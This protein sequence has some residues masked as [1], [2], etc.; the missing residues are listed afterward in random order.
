MERSR[1]AYVIL[2]ILA[3]EDYQSGYEIRK[4]IE[5]S[6]GFF[7]GES[8]GQIYPTLKRLIA[9]GLILSH[10]PAAT[11]R[12]QSREYC[13]TP[14]GRR[15]L[16]AWLAVP[17]RDDPP[18]D[19]FLLKLFF[20]REAEPGVVLEHL[21]IFQE[22]HRRFLAMMLEVESL[23][24]ARNS[25]QPGFPYWMLTLSYGVARVQAE[26]RVERVCDGTA[27]CP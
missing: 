25:N 16:Q 10:N 26:N 2:G 14:A 15:Q 12:R 8:Y 23:A 13:I 21:R 5:T 22:K 9:E 27:H 18:R 11:G 20:G 7:W 4:T 19:E 3:W 24:R 1:T 17:Y 6:V